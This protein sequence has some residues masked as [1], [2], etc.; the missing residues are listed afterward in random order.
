MYAN[1]PLNKIIDGFVSIKEI[2]A[3]PLR[4]TDW[5]CYM[6]CFNKTNKIFGFLFIITKRHLHTKQ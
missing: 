6:I 2:I 3:S 5:F 4:S 1:F